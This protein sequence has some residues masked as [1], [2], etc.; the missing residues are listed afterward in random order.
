MIRSHK[1]II[2]NSEYLQLIGLKELAKQHLAELEYI[3]QAASAITEEKNDDGEP[4]TLGHTSDFLY[5]YRD[6]QELLKLLNLKVV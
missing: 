4:E 1:E 3:N 6:I 2:T 5:D